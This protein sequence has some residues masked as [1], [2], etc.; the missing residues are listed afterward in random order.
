MLC[1]VKAV[2]TPVVF[3]VMRQVREKLVPALRMVSRLRWNIGGDCGG[4]G[5]QKTMQ[6]SSKLI[7]RKFDKLTFH[8]HK[9]RHFF[10]VISS[11]ARYSLEGSAHVHPC[12]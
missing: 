3:G 12:L 1:A 6:F 4:T 10:S 7:L 11:Y 5:E 8:S 2:S 9:K